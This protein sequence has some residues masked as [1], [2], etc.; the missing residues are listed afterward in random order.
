MSGIWAVLARWAGASVPWRAVA[1]R[2]ILTGLC[3]LACAV[4]PTLVEDR[5]LYRDI[6]AVRALITS[7]NLSRAVEEVTGPL[8]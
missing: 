4:V 5:P 2:G 3:P 7:G 8:R 6:A 1:G